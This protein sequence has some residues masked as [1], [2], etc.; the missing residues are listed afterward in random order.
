[1]SAHTR[2]YLVQARD[3]GHRFM[4]SYPLSWTEYECRVC[5]RK[6]DLVVMEFIPPTKIDT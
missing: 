5:G 1:M 6:T 4:F 3:C 2:K